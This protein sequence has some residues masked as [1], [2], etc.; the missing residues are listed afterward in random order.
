MYVI[1]LNGTSRIIYT[2]DYESN[3]L[4]HNCDNSIIGECENYVH[5]I[6]YGGTN[7]RDDK[8]FDYQFRKT[9]R[10]NNLIYLKN[11]D[12]ALFKSFFLSIFWRISISSR[13]RF[14]DTSLGIHEE[15]IR[16]MILNRKPLGEDDYPCM[17]RSCLN[18]RHVPLDVIG[19]PHHSTVN[20]E[21]PIT[22]YIAGF[23]YRLYLSK[24]IRP[25]FNSFEAISQIGEIRIH[26][27]TDEECKQNF[28]HFTGFKLT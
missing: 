11:L 18:S 5:T 27:L 19:P 1:S 10:N 2:G 26:E 8:T 12:Y 16:K 7:L 4:C 13:P 9:I 24:S 22:I 28:E 14:L 17:I 23:F 3:I 21:N 15:K 6:L 20:P 25:K